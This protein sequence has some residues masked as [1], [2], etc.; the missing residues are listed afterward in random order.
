M[1]TKKEQGVKRSA[2][3]EIKPK[4]AKSSRGRFIKPKFKCECKTQQ[5]QP[6]PMEKKPKCPKPKVKAMVKSTNWST[7]L[8]DLDSQMS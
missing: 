3:N 7:N 2:D 4:N 8:S 5:L 6:K 1:A